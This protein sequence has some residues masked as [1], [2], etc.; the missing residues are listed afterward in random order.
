TNL[1]AVCNKTIQGL[2]DLHLLVGVYYEEWV[3]VNVTTRRNAV[4]YDDAGDLDVALGPG[5]VT[6]GGYQKAAI[7]GGFVRVDYAFKNRYLLEVNGR[8]DGSSKFPTSQQWAFFPSASLGWRITEEGF[9]NV[10]P[11][12][13]SEFKLRASYGSLGNGNINPYAFTENFQIS[14]SG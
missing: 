3:Y 12:A 14:Q 9:W 4:V 6:N 11:Q 10:N 5:V 2:H 8:Y 7:A 13:I 1:Y